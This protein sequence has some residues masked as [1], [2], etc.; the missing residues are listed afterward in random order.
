MIRGLLALVL[1]QRAG[2]FVSHAL[3]LPV[4]GP[5]LGM[6]LLLAVLLVRAGGRRRTATRPADATSASSRPAEATRSAPLAPAAPAGVP[7][8]IGAAADGLIRH[9]RVHGHGPEFGLGKTHQQDR[10]DGLQLD[11]VERTDRNDHNRLRAH[12]PVP[13]PSATDRSGG[14]HATR[15]HPHR[16]TDGGIY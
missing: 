2:D 4:P 12:L 14:L 16:I 10:A 13:P 8:G 6:A 9:A 11:R 1:C 5:V 15:H 3:A 7:S